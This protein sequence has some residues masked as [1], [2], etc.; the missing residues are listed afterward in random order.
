MVNSQKQEKPVKERFDI[1]VGGHKKRKAPGICQSWPESL[2]QTPT[3]LLFQKFLNP[4][5]GPENFQ[6][7]NPTP[8]QTRDVEAEA[9]AGSGSG[10]SGPFSVE[11][12]ARK[13]YRFRFHVGYLTCRVTWQKKFCPFPNVD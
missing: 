10:G 9:E 3:P 7:E 12:E 4:D 2:F 8:V 11:V 13:F 6:I 5:P 1:Q